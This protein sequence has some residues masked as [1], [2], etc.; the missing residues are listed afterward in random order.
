[1]LRK[2]EKM[3]RSVN[4]ITLVG[5]CG[6]DPE[7]R[8][9]PGGKM[10]A[11]VNIATNRQRRGEEHTDWFSCQMWDKL[12]EL[13]MQLLKK[14]DLVFIQGRMEMRTYEKNGEKRTAWEVSVHTFVPMHKSKEERGGYSGG[15]GG[16][17]GGGGGYGGGGQSG[18]G[19]SYGGKEASYNQNQNPSKPTG[20]GGDWLDDP[21]F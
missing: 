9:L 19:G 3:A 20:G 21:P 8:E 1:V 17:G 7:M 4:Q 2:E 14:G 15:G 11:E 10:K 5:R 12:A 6:S 16:Y 18:G 13:S